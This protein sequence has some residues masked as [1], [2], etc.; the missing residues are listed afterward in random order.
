[1]A[2]SSRPFRATS[3]TTASRRMAKLASSRCLTPR[4]RPR[5]SADEALVL[6]RVFGS[7]LQLDA[8]ALRVREDPDLV[9]RADVPCREVQRDVAIE[10]GNPDAT[11]LDVHVLPALR[12]DVRV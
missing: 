1:M 12:L 2:S 3:R 4:A 6:E 10:L 11:R 9:D 7:S 5:F 8:V